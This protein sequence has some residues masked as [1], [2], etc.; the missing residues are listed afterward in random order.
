VRVVDRQLCL[1]VA[2]LVPIQPKGPPT[3]ATG[4]LVGTRAWSE[5]W[6]IPALLQA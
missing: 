3:E 1:L 4:S 2:L 5:G 6:S